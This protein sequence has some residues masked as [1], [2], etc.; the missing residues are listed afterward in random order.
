MT[1]PEKLAKIL[2]ADKD[3]LRL[4]EEKL[5]AASGK[6]GVMDAIVAENQ[7]V[8]RGRM[9]LLGLDSQAS[10]REIY[11]AL[12]RKIGADDE[13]LYRWLGKPSL[14][15]TD[16]W[17][18]ILTVALHVAGAPRGIFLKLDKAVELLHREQPKNIL[19]A[20]KYDTVD[21]MLLHED[22][23][24]VYCALRFIEGSE[25]LNGV[26]FKQYEKLSLSDFEFRPITTRAFSE[27]WIKSSDGFIRKKH[28]NISHLKEL[29]VIFTLPLAMD[30][31]GEL[32][33]NFGLILH[34][35][36]EIPFYSN[37]FEAYAQ[38][39]K[40]FTKNLVQLLSGAT[41]D[42]RPPA[43]RKSQWLVIQ[44]YLSKDD[45][46][47]WRLFE[48]HLN[49][50]AIHWDRAEVMLSTCLT[51]N[52]PC[53]NLSF[54]RDL[55]WVGNFFRTDAGTEA[56]VSFNL[57]DTAMSLVKREEFLRYLYHHQESLWNKIFDGYFGPKEKE[58]Y[59]KEYILRGWFEI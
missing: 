59:I 32:M 3:T 15:N 26:F 50:E 1:A 10:A 55:G 46:N 58:R 17:K 29:G 47:D 57:I 28:H 14:K 42:A 39:E 2:R 37:L 19:A 49:P 35:F 36:N 18:R 33:R 22:V 9:K 41:V 5:G 8:I 38:D 45:E 40:T 43:S 21:K 4:V 53:P 56:L 11:D 34:Y 12:I 7:E 20:L 30:V 48:P 27:R 31:S 23:L 52:E 6:R 25:W 13:E 54:W 16:D 24:E 51:G 44:R